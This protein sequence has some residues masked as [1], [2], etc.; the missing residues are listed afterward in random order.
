MKTSLFLLAF[1]TLASCSSTGCSSPTR[2]DKQK[3]AT[4]ADLA[5]Y[6][7]RKCMVTDLLASYS[8][9]GASYATLVALLGEPQDSL[10]VGEVVY[11]IADEY[12]SDIDPVYSKTLSFK[13][14]RHGKVKSFNVSEWR[15]D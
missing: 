1:L 15:A 14:D 12:G 11:K 5:S 7:F 2:F 8:L 6:P 10:T 4:Q 13:L 3:W 9:T